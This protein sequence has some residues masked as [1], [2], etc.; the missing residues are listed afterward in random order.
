M[1]GA[2]QDA[3][4]VADYVSQLCVVNW[5]ASV[6]STYLFNPYLVLF[7]LQEIVNTAIIFLV[8]V[9]DHFIKCF[10]F[11]LLSF[12]SIIKTGNEKRGYINYTLV[13]VIGNSI[14][15]HWFF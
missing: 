1:P 12:S 11:C 3:V 9:D 2:G 6:V 8:T 7:V 5:R 13:K 10:L 4:V 14:K 15:S